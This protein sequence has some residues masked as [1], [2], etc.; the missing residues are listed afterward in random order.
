MLKV[1]TDGYE[2]P[3]LTHNQLRIRTYL[4][5][6]TN[7]HA[8]CCN[9]PLTITEQ[10]THVGGTGSVPDAHDWVWGRSDDI[11]SSGRMSDNYQIS[12]TDSNAV[13]FWQRYWASGF[14]APNFTPPLI[15]GYPSGIVPLMILDLTSKCKTGLFGTQGMYLNY[16]YV[17]VNGDTGPGTGCAP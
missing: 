1:L 11:D 6:D 15:S 7:G 8:W 2:N 14:N 5:R 17:G 4:V 9:N 13:S 10:F 3:A 16:N 12:P